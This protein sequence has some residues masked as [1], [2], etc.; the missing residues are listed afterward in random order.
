LAFAR[1][2]G[3]PLT[4]AKTSPEGQ[5]LRRQLLLAADPGLASTLD[6]LLNPPADQP[7]LPVVDAL[8]ALALTVTADHVVAGSERRLPDPV[9]SS[10]RQLDRLGR[11]AEITW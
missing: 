3:Q 8:D 2:H 5:A 9:A 6:G 1:L 10:E 7:V 4:A 11:R